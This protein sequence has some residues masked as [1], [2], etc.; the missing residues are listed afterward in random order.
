MVRK[1]KRAQEEMVG[2]AL[3]IIIVAVIMLVFLNLSLKSPAKQAVESYEVDSF[4]QAFLQYDTDCEEKETYETNYLSVQELIFSCN[5]KEKCLDE[6]DT[7]GVLESTLQEIIGESWKIG[8]DYP[9]K[10][11][12]MNITAGGEEIIS[13]EEGN[14]T[15]NY[16]GS[17]QDFVKRGSRIDILFTAYY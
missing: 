2:F 15:K 10:G 6:R 8:A 9:V 13:F 11:Y 14:I 3:I 4:I 17:S 12:V 7:C 1:N 5:D 16:K